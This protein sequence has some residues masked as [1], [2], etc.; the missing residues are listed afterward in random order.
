MS[1]LD[2][3]TITRDACRSV[4]HNLGFSYDDVQR[5]DIYMLEA[6]IAEELSKFNEESFY[7]MHIAHRASD[8]P[9]IKVR[10]DTDC[11]I[12]SAFIRVDVECQKGREAISFNR[13]GFIGFAGWADDTN[14]QPF[15]RAFVRWALEWMDEDDEDNDE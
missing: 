2:D 10:E 1:L 6:L 14:V 8:A 4:F 11:G 3:A 7:Q 9:R 5:N 12:E 15:L 13:D